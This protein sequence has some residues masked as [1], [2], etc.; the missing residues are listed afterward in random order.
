MEDLTRFCSNCGKVVKVIPIAYL[1]I[2]DKG[3]YHYEAI[4]P[5][6]HSFSVTGLGLSE[7]VLTSP[8]EKFNLI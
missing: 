7:I 4:C 2:D 8:P 6:G 5:A 1:G 3:Y